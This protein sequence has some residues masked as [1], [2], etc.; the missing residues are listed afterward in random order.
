MRIYKVYSRWWI[1]GNCPIVQ[2]LYIRSA[3]SCLF[4]GGTFSVT[5]RNLGQLD[6][7]IRLQQFTHYFLHKW[8]KLGDKLGLNLITLLKWHRTIVDNAT[9]VET[10]LWKTTIFEVIFHLGSN[11]H[12][13]KC[14]RIGRQTWGMQIKGN[15]NKDKENRQEEKKKEVIR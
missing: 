5:S 2:V 8:R 6:I 3:V 14:L 11:F 7:Y 4:N 15:H 13:S 12:L 10:L 9:P 1:L